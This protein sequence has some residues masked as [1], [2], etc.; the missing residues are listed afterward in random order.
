M[1]ATASVDDAVLEEE[2]LVLPVDAKPLAEPVWLSELLELVDGA[3]LAPAELVL[4][5]DWSLLAT[6]LLEEL[7]LGVE[8]WPSLL[9]VSLLAMPLVLFVWLRELLELVEGDEA[10]VLEFA[11]V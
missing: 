4:L 6:V 11:A 8:F 2:P 10:A 7:L 5:E 9:L 3:E 1:L